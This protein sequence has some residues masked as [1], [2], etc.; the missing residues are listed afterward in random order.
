[1]ELTFTA[2]GHSCDLALHPVSEK[3]A[4]RIEEFGT[5]VYSM[6]ALE[7]WRKGKTATWGMKI[8]DI[9]HIQ[10]ALD[11]K[12]VE[13]DYGRIVENPLKIRRRMYLD[14]RAKYLCVLGFDNEICKFSWSWEI[15]DEFDPSKFEFMVHQWDRIMGEPNYYI[16]DEVRYGEAFATNHDWCDPSGF[17]LVEPRIIDLDQVRLELEL[18]APEH[19]GPPFPSPNETADILMD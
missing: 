7:W 11:G 12:P 6:R 3:T 16:L 5:E 13:F 19:E 2:H 10:V 9:C 14:S 1:M 8:D 15:E 4:R 18:G 17:T